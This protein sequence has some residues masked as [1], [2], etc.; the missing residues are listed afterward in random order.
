MSLIIGTILLGLTTQVPLPE[1]AE[2]TTEGFGG[3]MAGIGLSVGFGII[4]GQLLSDSGGAR[5]IARTVVG[6]TSQRFSMYGLAIAAFL[7]SIPVFY[8]HSAS[9]WD[10]A[11]WPH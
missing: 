10:P 1:L 2:A 4:L 6:L 3:L 11:P 9:P 5:V 7:L 8:E